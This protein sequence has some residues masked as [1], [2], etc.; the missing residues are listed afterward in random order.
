MTGNAATFMGIAPTAARGLRSRSDGA[1]PAADLSSLRAF[2]STGEAWDEP[3]WHWL[4]ETVGKK[5]LPVLNYTGGTETGGGILSCY[6]IAP[7]SP[8]SFCGPLPGMDVDVLDADGKPT[9]EIG[10]LV[11]RNTWPGMAHSFWNDRERYL[12]TYWSRWPGV[13]V[14]GD[15]CSID[16][17]GYWRIHGRSDDTLKIGGRRGP[18]GSK[19]R[20]RGGRDWCA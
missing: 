17:K 16:A 12:D 9:N 4:F 8:A 14:H 5:R 15:L 7:Q 13:W 6:T 1:A 11:M 20:Y 3:T 2:A 19:R 18:G 10:E